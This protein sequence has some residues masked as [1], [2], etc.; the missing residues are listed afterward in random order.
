MNINGETYFHQM[1]APSLNDQVLEYLLLIKLSLF[2]LNNILNETKES[3][4][5]FLDEEIDNSQKE[6][7]YQSENIKDAAQQNTW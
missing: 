6:N 7:I 2:D 4:Y 1:P 3:V 5:D